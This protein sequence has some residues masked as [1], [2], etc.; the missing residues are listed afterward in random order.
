MT[1][2]A[3]ESGGRSTVPDLFR[4]P[5][6]A[7][8]IVLL[9]MQHLLHFPDAKADF[10][11]HLHVARL[12]RPPPKPQRARACSATEPSHVQARKPKISKE[13]LRKASKER[14]E[15]STALQPAGLASETLLK[16]PEQLSAAGGSASP[17]W[18]CTEQSLLGSCHTV[19]TSLH[20]AMGVL[21]TPSQSEAF[22][23]TTP[24][25]QAIIPIER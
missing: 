6:S 17:V 23:S 18:P 22:R 10:E 11:D 9:W 14:Y 21:P 2:R 5:T 16:L 25:Q 1:C 20:E 7:L 13:R 15:T 4:A 12:R 8:R 19:V 24:D 3:I